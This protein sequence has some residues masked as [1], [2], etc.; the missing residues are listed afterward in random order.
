LFQ[1][2]SPTEGK[3]NTTAAAIIVRMIKPAI[4]IKPVDFLARAREARI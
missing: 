3:I 4:M 1:E 2:G